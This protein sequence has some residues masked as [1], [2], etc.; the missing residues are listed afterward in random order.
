MP[1]ALDGHA[2]EVLWLPDGTEP[3]D[4]DWEEAVA[5]ANLGNAIVAVREEQPARA[6]KKVPWIRW[7]S[8]VVFAPQQILAAYPSQKA[9]G[10]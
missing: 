4:K 6:D 5:W 3:A 1:E 10:R 2:T 7:D 9:K 8:T